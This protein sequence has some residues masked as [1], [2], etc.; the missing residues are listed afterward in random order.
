MTAAAEFVDVSKSYGDRVAL[1][2]FTLEIR[3]G[4]VLGLVGPNGAGKTTA[5]RCLVGLHAA[6]SG[7][8]RVDGIDVVSRP[9]EARRKLAFVP[10]GA[11]LYANL[12]A[13]AHLA[14][15]ARL[16]GLDEVTLAAESTRLLAAF[17]LADRGDDPV[18]AFS[19]GM[20]QK[21]ALACA[22]IARP[23]L[24]VLDE[25]LEGLD[26]PTTAMVKEL[27]RAW[28]NRGGAV[29]YTSH[30]LDVVERVCDRIAVL[31]QGEL[32]ASGTLDELRARSG[33]EGTLEQVFQTLTHAEDPAAAARRALG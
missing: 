19:R 10:D 13:K 28:A 15:V 14:L 1:R 32:V 3:S 23:K 21:A 31:Y 2:G 5:L 22:L 11:P 7:A 26:A 25:P 27:L 4:E 33:D 17:D 30:L 18:G 12:S 20:R 8:V 9:L 24:L 6:D 16:H 29:L